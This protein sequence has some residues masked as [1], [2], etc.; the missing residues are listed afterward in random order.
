MTSQQKWDQLLKTTKVKDLCSEK[1]KG[2]IYVD[3]R[4]TVEEVLKILEK[5]N[6][7]SVPVVDEEKKEFYGFVDVL[8]IAGF[9]LDTWK[10]QSYH[11]DDVHFPSDPFFKSP[12]IDVLNYSEVDYPVYIEED[13]SVANLISIFRDPK[14]YY[15]LHRCA[16]TQNGDVVNVVSQSDVIAFVAKHIDLFPSEKKDMQIGLIKG[17]IRSPIMIRLDSRFSDALERLYKN[18]ISGLALVDHEFKLSGNLSAS[19]LRVTLF[20]ESTSSWR[21]VTLN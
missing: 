12:I 7:L 18:R 20:K 13:A 15:R 9:I 21:N 11:L 1:K 17:F 2:L 14:N 3:R 19:D 5:E 16:V 6:I 8:D 4:I 10:K